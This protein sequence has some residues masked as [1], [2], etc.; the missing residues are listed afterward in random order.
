MSN[1][2]AK[3]VMNPRVLSVRDDMTLHELATFLTE[4]EISGV[5]VLDSGGKLVGVVSLTDIALSEAERAPIEREQSGSTFDLTT[6][7]KQFNR[8]DLRV[9]FRWW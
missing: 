8:E 2:T 9:S 7:K 6:W 1:L 4:N 5:P 3:D